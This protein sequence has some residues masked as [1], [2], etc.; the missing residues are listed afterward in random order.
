[1]VFLRLEDLTGGAEVGRLQLD[2]RGRA[3]AVRAPTGSSSSRAASTTEEGETKLIAI[4]VAAFE[5]VAERSEVRLRIDAR[6]AP[7]G[8]IRELAPLVQRVPRRGA[9]RTRAGDVARARGRS[10]SGPTTASQP[11]ADFFAEV[12]ALLGEAAV[13]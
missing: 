3:R 5:A 12:K 2:L 4:E 7:A 13:S 11:E 10:R 8:V 9:G 1:M 6:Q